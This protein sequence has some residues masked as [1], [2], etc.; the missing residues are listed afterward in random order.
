M[1]SLSSH[2]WRLNSRPLKASHCTTLILHSLWYQTFLGT[3]RFLDPNWFQSNSDS[4]RGRS[5]L[6]ASLISGT[7]VLRERKANGPSA[8]YAQWEAKALMLIWSGSGPKLKC[9][10]PQ[11]ASIS[12]FAISSRLTSAFARSTPDCQTVLTDY[13]RQTISLY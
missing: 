13:P 3:R 2:F 7:V 1:P 12:P 4:S 5:I 11:R 8:D 6:S 9:C 10:P